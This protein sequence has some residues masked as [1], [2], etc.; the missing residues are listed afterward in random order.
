MDSLFAPLGRDVR[1]GGVFCHQTPR[2]SFRYRDSGTWKE[3]ACELGDLLLVVHYR[4]PWLEELNALLMQFK[5]GGFPK[6]DP[7]DDQWRLYSEWPPFAWDFDPHYRRSPRPQG[8]HAGAI[9]AA[10]YDDGRPPY[11]RPADEKIQPRQLASL[12]N[13][14]ALLFGGRSFKGRRLARAEAHGGWS[15][16]IWDLI[17]VTATRLANRARSGAQGAPRGEG[18]LPVLPLAGE[19]PAVFNDALRDACAGDRELVHSI[20]ERAVR[21][22]ADEPPPEAPTPFDEDESDDDEGGV[23]VLAVE[24]GRQPAAG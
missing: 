4:E 15:E 24:I 16:V 19:P 18:L 17:E 10:I 1:V 2:V 5:V 13:G 21:F 8:P 12:L 6:E 22:D 11:G 9:H 20:W 23:S 7:S 14:T 3:G